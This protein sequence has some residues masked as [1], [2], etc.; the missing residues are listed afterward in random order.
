MQ[1]FTTVGAI[2]C[3][4]TEADATGFHMDLQNLL[5]IS[6]HYAKINCTFSCKIALPS[7]QL[8][9]LL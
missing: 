8:Q 6:M 2:G 4:I 7:V 1:F 3:G 5:V 9:L